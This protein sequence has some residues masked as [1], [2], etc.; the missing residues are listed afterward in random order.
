MVMVAELVAVVAAVFV[1]TK[2][3]GCNPWIIGDTNASMSALGVR[4]SGR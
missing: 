1:S 3:R 2:V 4:Q